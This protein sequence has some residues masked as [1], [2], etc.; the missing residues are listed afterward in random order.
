MTVSVLI[1]GVALIPQPS[2]T[3]WEIE[4]T[5]G[6]LDGTDSTGAY[7]VHILKAPVHRGAVSNWATYDNQVL[8]SIQTHAPGDTMRG[9]AVVYSSGVVSKPIT[10]FNAPPGGLVKE[11]ELRLMVIV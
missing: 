1:N 9:T 7:Q 8:T 5:G 6:K 3:S 2:E 4:P 10:R 11:V